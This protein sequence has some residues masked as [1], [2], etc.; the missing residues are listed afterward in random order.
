MVCDARQGLP[1][2]LPEGPD[3][4]HPALRVLLPTL[5]QTTDGMPGSRPAQDGRQAGGGTTRPRRRSRLCLLALK[6]AHRSEI[7]LLARTVLTAG[8][9]AAGQEVY[10]GRRDGRGRTP[11]DAVL[12]L[13]AGLLTATFVGQGSMDLRSQLRAL[14]SGITRTKPGPLACANCRPRSSPR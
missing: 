12:P 3:R 8:C 2:E 5:R 9:L 6:V 4:P 7:M 1:R 11:G 10:T 14:S 13:A